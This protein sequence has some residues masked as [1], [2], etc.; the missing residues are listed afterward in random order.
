MV[1]REQFNDRE[2]ETYASGAIDPELMSKLVAHRKE[3]CTTYALEHPNQVVLTKEQAINIGRHRICHDAAW[4]LPLVDKCESD[5]MHNF[6]DYG[7]SI[8]MRIELLCMAYEQHPYMEVKCGDDDRLYKLL[9]PDGMTIGQL[10]WSL[11]LTTGLAID[12]IVLAQPG[13]E[14]PD[15]GIVLSDFEGIVD[16]KVTYYQRQPN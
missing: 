15:E 14:E 16:R 2:L 9:T 10:K 13:L 3:M 4:N 1:E 6:S 7:W 12:R 8:P 11:H 5:R